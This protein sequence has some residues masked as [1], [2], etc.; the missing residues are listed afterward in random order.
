MIRSHQWL[1]HG[2]SSKEGWGQLLRVPEL[3]VYGLGVGC[4]VCVSVLLM[5]EV[6]VSVCVRVC[7]DVTK[8]HVGLWYR[9]Y[10]V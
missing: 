4:N 8:E 3:C 9:G 10:C 5:S 7:F 2:V 1:A 6:D